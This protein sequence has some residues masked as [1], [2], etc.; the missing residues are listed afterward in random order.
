MEYSPKRQFE[1]LTQLLNSK[2]R[3]V[4]NIDDL[5]LSD[6]LSCSINGFNNMSFHKPSSYESYN[7]EIITKLLE[8]D[9]E[10]ILID[11][12]GIQKQIEELVI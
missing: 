4:Q 6:S 2:K 9:R 11:L 8:S 10:K 7:K 1:I 5:L 12:E 3:M